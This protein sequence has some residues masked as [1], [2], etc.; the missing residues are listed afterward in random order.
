M[1]S[2]H[3]GAFY[4]E[5]FPDFRIG[6][7]CEPGD[8][9]KFA[10]I[11]AVIIDEIIIDVQMHHATENGI[12]SAFFGSE[13][14]HPVEP[15]F[16]IDRAFSDPWRFDHY[17]V[18]SGETGDV[19]LI[20]VIVVDAG[21]GIHLFGDVLGRYVDNEFAAGTDV[22]YRILQFNVF[23]VF[24]GKK[25]QGHG[26]VTDHV[27]KGK[28]CQVA[29]PVFI[30]G[31][32]ECDGSWNHASDKQLVALLWGK[33]LGVDFHESRFGVGFFRVNSGRSGNCSQTGRDVFSECT[34]ARHHT[35]AEIPQNRVKGGKVLPVKREQFHVGPGG[36]RLIFFT[37]HIIEQLPDLQL[38]VIPEMFETLQADEPG[39]TVSDPVQLPVQGG[40]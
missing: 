10:D 36:G 39:L 25:G 4:I 6:I 37:D 23:L 18:G 30:Y 11:D 21:C 8:G 31:R 17:R 35:G 5:D 2:S 34:Q 33:F 38:L 32:Y 7:A 20:N 12:A 28:R 22:F 19:K 3:F 16:K 40:G 9:F 29:G 24:L 26:V 27:E 15:A 14:D 1:R 13:L